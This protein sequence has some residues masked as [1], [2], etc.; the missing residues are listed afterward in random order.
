M[1]SGYTIATFHIRDVYHGVGS[2]S[3]DGATPFHEERELAR[4]RAIN[5]LSYTLSIV[6]KSESA[7]R[8][9]Q[10]G[11]FKD[12]RVESSIFVTTRLVLSGVETKESWT[13]KE[14]H[15]HWVLVPL[16]KKRQ[17]SK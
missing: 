5:D 6:I 2:A 13:D 17:T 14:K 15:L 11:D 9:A 3:F 10:E 12:K 8:I 16:K 1:G 7:N 4:R